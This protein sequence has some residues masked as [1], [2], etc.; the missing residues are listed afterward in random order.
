M[1]VVGDGISAD[2]QNRCTCRKVH[3]RAGSLCEGCRAAQAGGNCWEVAVSPCCDL[4]RTTCDSCPTYV[5]A[6]RSTTRAESVRVILEGGISVEGE[7]HLQPNRRMSDTF[8]DSD[9]PYIV[10]THAVIRYPDSEN[11][12]VETHEMILLLKDAARMVYPLRS[13]AA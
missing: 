4:P 5:A 3:P 10:I 13:R 7:I 1:E 9:K 8:N 12:P 2:M 11:R 6:L